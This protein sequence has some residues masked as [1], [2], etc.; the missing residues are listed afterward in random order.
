MLT[1]LLLLTPNGATAHEELVDQSPGDGESVEAGIVEVRLTFSD[2]LLALAGGS[3]SEIVILNADGMPLNNGCAA[4]DG[5]VATAKASIETPGKY[6]VG[7]R[8][9]SGDGHPISDSFTFTVVNT[10]GYVADPDYL[11]IECETSFEDPRLIV[12]QEQPQFIYW[13]LWGSLG[14]VAIGL[15][16]FLRPR[17]DIEKG[18]AGQD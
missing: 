9:I 17:K 13:I 7:W 8:A 11:F 18:Q 14:L 3:G 12:P 10:S 1:A 16:L 2:D 6:T 15:V 4:V 5:N